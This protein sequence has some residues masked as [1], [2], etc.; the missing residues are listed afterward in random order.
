[1]SMLLSAFDTPVRWTNSFTASGGTPRRRTPESVG[2]RGSS[3]PLTWPPLTS[4]IS[5]RFDSTVYL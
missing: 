2:R 1:M 4:A 3:Q 5:L